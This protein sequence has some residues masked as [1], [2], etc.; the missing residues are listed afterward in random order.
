MARERTEE[1]RRAT[2]EFADAVRIQ[3]ARFFDR[4]VEEVR[5]NPEGLR[6]RPEPLLEGEADEL[7]LAAVHRARQESPRRADDHAPSE[8]EVSDWA[9]KREEE[10]GSR[11]KVWRLSPPR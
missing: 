2:E 7:A 4:L 6:L 11:P 3:A 9:K 8:A 1:E 5:R 10:R